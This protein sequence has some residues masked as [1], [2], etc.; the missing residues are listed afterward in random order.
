MYMRR[1]I[2]GFTLLELIVVIAIIGVLSVLILPSF[3]N[4]LAR[5]ND[6]KLKQFA[7]TLDKKNDIVNKYDFEEGGGLVSK[8]SNIY[9]Q[10]NLTLPGS[11][12]T[13]STNTYSSSSQYSLLFTAPNI[14]V[15][16][17][18]YL[19][20]LDNSSFSIS[21]WVKRTAGFGAV[22]SVIF[23]KGNYSP[24]NEVFLEFWND[25]LCFHFVPAG[26]NSNCMTSTFLDTNWHHIAVSFDLSTNISKMYLDSKLVSSKTHSTNSLITSNNYPLKLGYSG[27][28]DFRGNIDDLRFFD[29]AILSGDVARLYAEGMGSGR[30]ANK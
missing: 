18:N 17:E 11:G 22:E 21:V 14:E 29:T 25:V 30:F 7:I 6:T 5:A 8:D 9:S 19:P 23:Y 1:P 27:G 10:N 15:V 16:S 3:K 12:V 4:A 26:S 20:K 24:G 28:G 2:R 13:F